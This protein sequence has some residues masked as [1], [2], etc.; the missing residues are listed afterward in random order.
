MIGELLSGVTRLLHF[1]IIDFPTHGPFI[2]CPFTNANTFILL[3]CLK[4]VNYIKRPGV[5]L[6]KPY[7]ENRPNADFCGR[8][9]RRIVLTE[10]LFYVFIY[11]PDPAFKV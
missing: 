11:C 10:L 2:T 5:Y 7:R 8:V 6:V 9:G 1:E 3:V 4:F